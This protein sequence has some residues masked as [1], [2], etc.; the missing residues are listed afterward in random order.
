MP[1]PSNVTITVGGTDITRNVLYP[2]AK[3]EAQASAGVG[4]FAFTV[5]DTA[6]S[7]SFVTGNE[8][9]LTLDGK[10]Y[11]GGYLMQVG[12][13]FAFPVV[14]TSNLSAVTA[15]QHALAGVN[16]NVLFDRLVVR[17]TA[18]Y[19]HALPGAPGTTMAG[20]LV[21]DLAQYLDLPAGLN[22]TTFVDDV[23]PVIPQEQVDVGGTFVWVNAGEQG[24]KWRE[25]MKWVTLYNGAV[26]YIDADKRLHFHAP[27]S[28]FS[29]WGFSD[30]PNR[31]TVSSTATNWTGATY[32]FR[33]ME[34]EEDITSMTN[35][36]LVWG[37]SHFISSTDPND[38]SGVVFARR[39][40]ADSIGAHGRWQT[41]EN[42]M[43]ELKVQ[44]AVDSLAE[45]IVPPAG[46]DAPPGVGSDGIIR[47][48]SWPN[49]TLRLSWYAHDVPTMTNGVKDHLTPGDIVTIIL[50]VHGRGEANPLI[51]TLPLRRITISFPTLPGEGTNPTNATQTYVRFDGEFGL[52]LDDPYNLWEAI[53]AARSRTSSSLITTTTSPGGMWQG[54]PDEAPDGSRKTFTLSTNGTPIVYA[55][56]TSEV[57]LGGLRLRQGADYSESPTTGTITLFVAPSTGTTF[58]VI[59]RLAG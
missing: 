7:L 1:V 41:A 13:R 32:G 19:L 49:R 56:G 38:P 6:R 46:S 17:N 22:T 23:A 15:R 26:Y 30:R 40:N 53:L 28:L 29:R 21:E 36:I 31:A 4:T 57:Y 20:H 2:S 35:D 37:G 16:Y 27:E 43:G 5:K 9:V 18:D 51:L 58:W 59:V 34:T 47:N 10:R 12:S 25:E 45:A 24:V 55:G 54:A 50:Y 39:Q 8:V 3:F 42:R 11:Y 52:S 44:S 48:R 33:E 14:N